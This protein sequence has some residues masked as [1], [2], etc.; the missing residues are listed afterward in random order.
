[1]QAAHH[2]VGQ[3]VADDVAHGNRIGSRCVE[4][5]ALGDLHA[6]RCQAGPVVRHVGCHHA[7]DAEA[8]I[9]AAV[10][11]RHVDAA[12]GQAG[13]AGKIDLDSVG[14]DGHRRVQRDRVLVAVGAD[15]GAEFSSRQPGDFRDR[16]GMR[17]FED[18]AGQRVH[19][20]HVEFVHHLLQAPHAGIVA[21]A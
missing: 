18:E 3:Q 5:A 21:C 6:E 12:L 17:A 13:G 8:G 14:Q 11:G 1:V 7:F 10:G 2:Q 19:A 15:L 16:C 4:D 9:G 20:V